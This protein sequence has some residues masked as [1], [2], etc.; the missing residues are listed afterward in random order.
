[1]WAELTPPPHT[2]GFGGVVHGGLV[3]TLLDEAMFYAIYATGQ[4]TMTVHL[5]TTL[6]K[7]AQPGVPVRVEAFYDGQERRYYLAH[8]TL[9]DPEGSVL[10]QA[11][12]RFLRVP[13]LEAHLQGAIIEEPVV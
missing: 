6:R 3:T 11:H 2:R 4:T 8:A 1:M 9:L 10:A 12:G 13:K 5:S 7:S